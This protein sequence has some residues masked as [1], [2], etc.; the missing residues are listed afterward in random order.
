MRHVLALFDAPVPAA[1][2]LRALSVAGF[3]PTDLWLAAEAPLPNTQ[4]LS[5]TDLPTDALGLQSE[6]ESRGLDRDDAALC[7]EGVTRRGAILVLVRCPSA[8]AP[9]AERILAAAAPP[10]L[11]MHRLRWQSQP[12]ARHMWA[13]I[14]PPRT[15]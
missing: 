12:G 6:L 2:A 15:S 14:E 9:V 1:S 5:R 4:H 13:H 10:D 8:A 11:A 7:A 3:A